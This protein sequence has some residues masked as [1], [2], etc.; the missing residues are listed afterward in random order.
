VGQLLHTLPEGDAVWGVTSLDNRLYVLRNKS[1]QQIEVYDTQS[2][3]LLQRLSV[4]LL[5]AMNDI[6]S[7]AHNRCLYIA[8]GGKDSI[9]R[10]GLRIVW[11]SRPDVRQWSVNDTP[12][13]LSVTDTHSLLVMCDEVSKIKEFSAE[14]KL[15]RQL[16]LPHDV[17][18][19]W[20]AIQSSSGAFVLCHG[21]AA[22]P[23]H[24]V[25]LVGADGQVVKSYGGPRGSDGQQM[26][27]PAHLKVDRNG[28]VFAADH[29][30]YRVLL[31]SPALT[32]VREVVSRGQLKWKP[33]RLFLDVDRRRLYVAV[34]VKVGEFT[35]GRVVAFNV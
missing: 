11:L 13:G 30:N 8:D 6:V 23:L 22:D 27:V 5:G 4:P 20:H 7:C 29:N 19:P 35:A 14:G 17:V 1:S 10:V 3:R 18:S 12:A 32:Y 34:N 33:H 21:R 31:L 9:H 24:R 16:E 28:F 15:L 25:C 2:Y 26:N